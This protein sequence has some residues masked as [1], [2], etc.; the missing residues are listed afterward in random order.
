M[1]NSATSIKALT[2]TGAVALA[3]PLLA[4][5]AMPAQAYVGPG[6]GLSLLSA[7]WA[8]IAAIGI[9]IG[10]V[11]LWPIRKM[12]RKR[13]RKTGNATNNATANA[14]TAA[15]STMRTDHSEG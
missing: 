8:V 6:A 4:L 2:F 14:S 11:V 1:N 3:I 7:L 10:F 15:S 5:T 9:S 13:H 12:M